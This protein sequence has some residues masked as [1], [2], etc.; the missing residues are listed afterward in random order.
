MIFSHGVEKKN[1]LQSYQLFN[2]VSWTWFLGSLLWL[3][4]LERGDW[5]R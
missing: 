4:L 1:P 3:T 2:K 5:T